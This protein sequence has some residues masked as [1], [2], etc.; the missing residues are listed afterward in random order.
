MS[1]SFERVVRV[2]I[3]STFKDMNEERDYLLHSVFPEI[4]RKLALRYIEFYEIDLRWGITE[5]EAESGKIITLCIEEI[6]KSQPYFIGLIGER[7]GW[8]PKKNEIIKS[9]NIF[10]KYPR[11][12][13][14]LLT[15]LS[16]TEMEI[17]YGVL[18][19]EN[20]D[21][22]MQSMFFIK[23]INRKKINYRLLNL[24]KTLLSDKSVKTLEYETLSELGNELT[25]VLL[26]KINIKYPITEIL[27]P[28]NIE[29]GYHK[30]FLKSRTKLFVGRE[31]ILNEID[32][33]IKDGKNKILIYN[34]SGTGKSS[35]MSKLC[36]IK[37]QQNKFDVFYHFIGA[38][39]KSTQ[40]L[41]LLIRLAKFI[42]YKN[43]ESVV[44]INNLLLPEL[45]NKVRSQLTK[46]YVK[47]FLIVIDAI[48]QMEVND[49]ENSILSFIPFELSSDVIIV[50]STIYH[51]IIS[52]ME[53]NGFIKVKVDELDLDAKTKFIEQY[54]LSYGKKLSSEFIKK[55]IHD[56]VALKPMLLRTFLNEIRLFGN[57]EKLGTLID[58]LITPIG[59]ESFYLAVVARWESDLSLYL[60]KEKIKEI[61][62][63]IQLS[64]NGISEK[65]ILEIC[66]IRPLDLSI[67]L[68][69]I[70]DHLVSKNG[71]LHYSHGCI[72]TAI[73]QNYMQSDNDKI[74]IYNLMV[75]YFSKDIYSNR[76]ISELV[77]HYNSIKKYDKVIQLFTDLKWCN[78]F[79]EKEGFR[80]SEIEIKLVPGNL[81]LEGKMVKSSIESISNYP[82]HIKSAYN[83][84]SLFSKMYL[85]E[86]ALKIL[87]E[88]ENVLMKNDN[89][90]VL[91]SDVFLEIGKCEHH[92]WRREGYI[93]AINY[94]KKSLE[95]KKNDDT[96]H[97]EF[98]LGSAYLSLGQ[99]DLSEEYLL[100]AL[101]KYKSKQELSL[102]ANCNLRIGIYKYWKG[103]R[104]IGKWG[105][106]KP[107][108]ISGLNEDIFITAA[109]YFKNSLTL[110]LK[111]YGSKSQE[112]FLVL[113]Y[114]QEMYYTL[115]QWDLAIQWL[116]EI[117]YTVKDLSY[118]I[119][120]IQ[121]YMRF[122]TDEIGSKAER[123][124][125]LEKGILISKQLYGDNNSISDELLE[126]KNKI[127]NKQLPYFKKYVNIN[128]DEKLS[129][130]N[131]IKCIWKKVVQNSEI[132]NSNNW[133]YD[134]NSN[135]IYCIS[136]IESTLIKY[137]INTFE[138]ENITFENWPKEGTSVV[139]DKSGKGVYVWRSGRDIVYY[140][141]FNEKIFKQIGTGFH[142]GECY[143]SAIGL[144]K[145]NGFPFFFGG[146]GFF[147]K[148]NW[149][150]EFNIE[151]G[152]WEE[153]IKNSPGLEP[154]PMN[155][156][157]VPGK[158]DLTILLL[159]G[160]GNL[161]GLQRE[162]RTEKG[163]SIATDVGLWTWF[164]EVWEINLND[165]KAKRIIGPN[166]DTIY[167]HG[168]M[169]YL[170]STNLFFYKGGNVPP[171]KWGGENN[172]IEGLFA[173]Y[174]SNDKEF[175]KIA[176][177]GDVP[178][179]NING[180]FIDLNLNNQLLFISEKTIWTID[181]MNNL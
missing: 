41:N 38:S 137:D 18:D 156:N 81:L 55:I 59:E 138:M 2:F 66:T 27:D 77:Y 89:D 99:Y 63:L 151:N 124:N 84:A 117:V 171:M 144:N 52:I 102:I 95:L 7:Y 153:K 8:Q 14:S 159:C 132:L 108:L 13:K 168:A 33:I 104:A 173:K 75:K 135:S 23:K 31:S 170:R 174:G 166:D 112:S 90:N 127:N 24:R 129:F 141:S 82:E 79:I 160:V 130:R 107:E 45:L 96:S 110:N 17:R 133:L 68:N 28:D 26:A 167:C 172:Y 106:S 98:M 61:L 34:E 103:L 176:E 181:F 72:I 100:S 70:E 65:E 54:L 44:E 11:A 154:Y 46:N 64:R 60:H 87:I 161:S 149:F 116:E 139:L 163:I 118:S 4:R 40:Y 88:L 25:E 19:N 142:D 122:A 136:K 20:I 71:L 12:K 150:I 86:P 58:E 32:E 42:A 67:I 114:L 47:K 78:L 39:S 134:N 43:N 73:N 76:S 158:D 85:I 6:E 74:P 50:C 101:E 178:E 93:S 51:P 140:S 1:E 175:K 16:I 49:K 143:G 146:Y 125:M 97:I 123:L 35:I 3:S 128:L 36:E 126:L 121:S 109:I 80:N 57:H 91:F 120:L 29:D 177:V 92:R 5:N 10:D 21:S 30:S 83:V 48:N 157:I 169:G 164:R 152:N 105:D 15:G 56:D 53:S 113:H 148:K 162:Q 22:K 119:P 155:T 180:V 115:E 131:D 69:R 165:Y 9:I 94:Y 37:I 111:L 62:L 147:K 179:S 145:Q